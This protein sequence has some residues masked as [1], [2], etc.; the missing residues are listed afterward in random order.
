MSADD[1][2]STPEQPASDTPP[3]NPPNTGEAADAGSP[4]PAKRGMK[5]LF[6]LMG[7]SAFLSFVCCGGAYYLWSSLQQGLIEDPERVAEIRPEIMTIDL[8]D[9][10]KPMRAQI[11]KDFP[12]SL[13]PDSKTV[14]YQREGDPDATLALGLITVEKGQKDVVEER[15][16]AALD[17]QTPSKGID[18]LEGIEKIKVETVS[19]NG[20]DAD[21]HF[22]E[23]TKPDTGVVFRQVTSL[24]TE[25][26][27]VRVFI[28]REPERTTDDDA[29]LR[30]IKTIE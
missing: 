15:V 30:L 20:V 6:S 2:S 16:R 17:Q 28:L 11:I 7:V 12:F 26:D 24:W 18:E 1:S 27:Q 25:G 5:V 14:I 21:F 22:V 8:G 4:P 3:A 9:S 13:M 23:G 29:T 10:W 19:I